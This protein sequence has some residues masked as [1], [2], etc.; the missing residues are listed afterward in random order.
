M[1]CVV[2]HV[3]GIT[4]TC[5]EREVPDSVLHVNR[6]VSVCGGVFLV[7]GYVSA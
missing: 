1:S 2:S 6:L 5:L 4:G 7:L 3:L